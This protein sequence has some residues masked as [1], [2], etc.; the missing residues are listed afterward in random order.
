MLN[1]AIAQTFHALWSKPRQRL[2]NSLL[3]GFECR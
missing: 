1:E 2:G 3:L